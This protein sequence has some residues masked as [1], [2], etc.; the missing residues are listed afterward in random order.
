MADFFRNPH[1]VVQLDFAADGHAR[2]IEAA[3]HRE[4]AYRDEV[5]VV[6]ANLWAASRRRGVAGSCSSGRST[7][8]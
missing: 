3:P 4:V 2:G 5:V 7:R 1:E 6:L 8:S